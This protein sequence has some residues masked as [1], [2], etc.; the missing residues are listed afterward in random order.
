[1]KS[2]HT[3]FTRFVT[4]TRQ[5]TTMSTIPSS[6]PSS[7]SSF[8]YVFAYDSSISNENNEIERV[9]HFYPK[10]TSERIQCETSAFLCGLDA[11][12]STF[13]T[14]EDDENEEGEDDDGKEDEKTT[15][16]KGSSSESSFI[17][18]KTRGKFYCAVNVLSS[19]WC[20]V[21]EVSVDSSSRRHPLEMAQ[22][23]HQQQ[24]GNERLR[25]LR[26]VM[27]R[28]VK[29]KLFVND[30]TAPLVVV[31][32]AEQRRRGTTS[33]EEEE[34]RKWKE[35]LK[36]LIDRLGERLNDE[37]SSSSFAM[38]GAMMKTSSMTGT[39]EDED[40]AYV[41]EERENRSGCFVQTSA[42]K[43]L[44]ALS[45]ISK[46]EAT[47]LRDE[48]ESVLEEDESGSSATRTSTTI[49]RAT[50]P[51]HD[52][53][54]WARVIADRT[55]RLFFITEREDVKTLLQANDAVNELGAA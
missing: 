31:A 2:L 29:E 35:E 53:W 20:A 9:V 6:S 5:Q 14:S 12:M 40:V 49:E 24:Q 36:R 43:S 55:K 37:S 51:G 48:M 17:G 34:K 52:A 42:S 4:H 19:V 10:E 16:K 39:K 32:D 7:S 26:D 46:R 22:Q 28:E 23:Q 30:D 47:K 21:V 33:G 41:L 18:A 38:G 44:D 27:E 45:L 50:R 25:L 13:L 8:Y 54:L 1:M 11:F 3:T 15:K